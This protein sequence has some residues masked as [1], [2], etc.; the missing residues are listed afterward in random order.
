VLWRADRTMARPGT[1]R[2]AS[3][4]ETLVCVIDLRHLPINRG[5]AAAALLNA[6]EKPSLAATSPRPT[7]S[8]GK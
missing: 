7:F 2:R 8:K 6:A 1:E 5:A 3:R 4:F